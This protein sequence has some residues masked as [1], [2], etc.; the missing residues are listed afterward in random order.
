MNHNK[1]NPAPRVAGIK[2]SG[3]ITDT[4]GMTGMA[5]DIAVK[6]QQEIIRLESLISAVNA[7]VE[8]R[9]LA[10]SNRIDMLEAKLVGKP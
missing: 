5:I 7:D 6:S 1:K 9:F 2:P 4:Y 10:L 3:P 8:S